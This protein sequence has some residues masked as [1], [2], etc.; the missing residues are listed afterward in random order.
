MVVEILINTINQL[1][2]KLIKLYFVKCT[3]L[4]LRVFSYL[5]II[6]INKNFYHHF[7]KNQ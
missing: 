3:F 5:R 6:S 2:N 1:L 4:N 7:I